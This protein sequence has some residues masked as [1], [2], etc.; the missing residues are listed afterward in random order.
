MHREKDAEDKS[1]HLSPTIPSL[2]GARAINDLCKKKT[3]VY[4]SALLKKKWGKFNLYFLV[5]FRF[6]LRQHGPFFSIRLVMDHSL[7]G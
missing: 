3:F 6:W 5:E 7:T 4:K 1:P 2:M